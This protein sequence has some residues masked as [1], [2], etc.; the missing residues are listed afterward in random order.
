MATASC[1]ASSAP[2]LG[3]PARF[4]RA[5]AKASRT[6]TSLPV[7]LLGP[8]C[9]CASFSLLLG[10]C[11][12]LLGLLKKGAGARG[13]ARSLHMPTGN[14]SAFGWVLLF[15]NHPCGTATSPLRARALQIRK[16][17]K[18]ERKRSQL[19]FG[20]SS[21]EIYEP[22]ALPTG[23]RLFW[24]AGIILGCGARLRLF[25]PPLQ[26]RRLVAHVLDSCLHRRLGA[27][28][29]LAGLLLRLCASLCLCLRRR[30]PLFCRFCGRLCCR[31]PLLCFRQGGE[32]QSFLRRFFLID[33]FS[34]PSSSRVPHPPPPWLRDG[35]GPSHRAKMACTRV[36]RSIEA[37]CSS[38]RKARAE[39]KAFETLSL[40]FRGAAGFGSSRR[41]G[42]RSRH[43]PSAQGAPRAPSLWP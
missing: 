8:A 39:A 37:Q 12:L 28:G 35:N 21:Q 1:R 3:L 31:C 41:E 10:R 29:A 24:E 9:A 36:L 25:R 2:A 34:F 16:K 32:E 23:A 42:W 22:L 6:L 15:L 13:V 40:S 5:L 26:G 17:T 33:S 7:A 20:R 11:Y 14:D 30:R 18:M 43:P 19:I 4:A 27:L 38:A